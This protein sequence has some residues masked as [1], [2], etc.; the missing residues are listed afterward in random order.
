VVVIAVVLQTRPDL[1]NAYG[2]P[3]IEL[4]PSAQEV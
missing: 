1:V 2:G 3:G 4:V